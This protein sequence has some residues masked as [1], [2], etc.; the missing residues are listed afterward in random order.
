MGWI[1]GWMPTFYFSFEE[2]RIIQCLQD[3]GFKTG[4][5]EIQ[6]RKGQPNQQLMFNFQSNI[7]EAQRLCTFVMGCNRKFILAACSHKCKEQGRM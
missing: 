5:V 6:I 3:D 4:G 1:D 2:R 7:S